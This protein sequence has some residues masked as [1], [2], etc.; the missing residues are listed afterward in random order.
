VQERIGMSENVTECTTERERKERKK[1]KLFVSAFF[2]LFTTV[3]F[4]F[5]ELNKRFV[6]GGRFFF[7]DSGGVVFLSFFRGGVVLWA[8]QGKREREIFK[9]REGKKD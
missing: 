3:D 8:K 1:N 6:C 5:L 4:N 9:K 2:V 7:F